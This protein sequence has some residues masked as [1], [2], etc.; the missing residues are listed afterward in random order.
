MADLLSICQ[1]AYDEVYPNA[2]A[3]TAIKVEHFI[4]AGKSKYAFELWR[5]SK[6]EKRLEGEWDIPSALLR[7]ATIE[8]A[9]NV[10]DISNL[11]IFRSFEGDTWIQ[12]IGDFNPE[13]GCNY[14]RQTVNVSRMLLDDEYLG[15]SKPYTVI[16]NSIKFPKGAHD[17]SIPIIY[18]SNGEDLEDQ[19]LID[20]A[21]GEIVGIYL[22]QR[23]SN[24]L[25]ADKSADSN[26]NTV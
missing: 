11:K 12:N 24:K 3:Q 9:D 7:E 16:G 15:N 10:A 23:F 5:I 2:T 1:V 19:I 13:D 26:E 20:D 21:I 18:A 8:V 4:E 6:E 25:P 22:V 14:I 17:K